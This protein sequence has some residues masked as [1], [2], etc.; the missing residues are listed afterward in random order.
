MLETQR[1]LAGDDY[2][3]KKTTEATAS[4]PND[5]LHQRQP[6]DDDAAAASTLLARPADEADDDETV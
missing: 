1:S 5:M 6:G 4:D 2:R 3:T